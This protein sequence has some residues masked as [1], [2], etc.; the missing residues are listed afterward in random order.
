VRNYDPKGVIARFCN[1]AF[2]KPITFKH[3]SLGNAKKYRNVRD[4]G[5]IAK[6]DVLLTKN[7]APFK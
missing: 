2:H 3:K 7:K 1:I 4:K 6:I 5:K